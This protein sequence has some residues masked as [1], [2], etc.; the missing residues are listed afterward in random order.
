[1]RRLDIRSEAHYN[2]C[3]SPMCN[4]NGEFRVH[5]GPGS[6]IDL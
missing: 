3:Q 6:Y 2:T 5:H 1:L 4:R